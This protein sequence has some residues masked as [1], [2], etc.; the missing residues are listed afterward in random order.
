MGQNP[1]NEWRRDKAEI[2]LKFALITNQ[3]LSWI[4]KGHN[5]LNDRELNKYRFG[6]WW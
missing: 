6:L 5:I 4:S 2:L 3:R 1:T